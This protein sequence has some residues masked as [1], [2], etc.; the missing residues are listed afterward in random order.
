M[1]TGMSL[2]HHLVSLMLNRTE[3]ISRLVDSVA[4][5]IDRYFDLL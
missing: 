4:F 1:L 3:V 5:N 2:R